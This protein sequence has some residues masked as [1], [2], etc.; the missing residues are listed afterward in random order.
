MIDVRQ[1]AEF[2]RWLRRLA[3]AQAVARIVGR[4]RRMEQGNFGD[5]RSVGTGVMEMR[6]DQGPGYRVYFVRHGDAVV[7]LLCAGDKRTQEKDIQRAR[8]MAEDY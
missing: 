7:I 3:D 5:V 6:I 8:K 4:I 2:A 1:T